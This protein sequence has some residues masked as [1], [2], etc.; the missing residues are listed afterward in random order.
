MTS[1]EELSCGSENSGTVV[2]RYTWDGDCDD[3]DCGDGDDDDDL[4]EY[5]EDNGGSPSSPDQKWR[6]EGE[7]CE[8]FS[9]LPVNRDGIRHI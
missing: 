2:T 4:R 5:G 6:V 3:D 8:R 9:E 1:V 7:D